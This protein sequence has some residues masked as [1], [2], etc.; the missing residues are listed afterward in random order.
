MKSEYDSFL[1]KEAKILDYEELKNGSVKHLEKKFEELRN[2]HTQANK[3]LP[4]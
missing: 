3:P 2:A 1:A 4:L